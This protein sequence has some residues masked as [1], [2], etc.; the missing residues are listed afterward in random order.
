MSSCGAIAPTLQQRLWIWKWQQPPAVCKLGG[1]DPPKYHKDI[2]QGRQVLRLVFA[3]KQVGLA[4]V[5]VG[6]QY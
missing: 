2:G 3:A 4:I 6:T 1:H 5:V